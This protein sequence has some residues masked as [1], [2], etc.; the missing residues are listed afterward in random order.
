M[1]L[2]VVY[3]A[4]PHDRRTGQAGGDWEVSQ[5]ICIFKAKLKT[6]LVK[7]ERASPARLESDLPLYIRLPQTL[8]K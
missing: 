6:A 1:Q 2:K 8:Q 7:L 4:D 3:L 5:Q